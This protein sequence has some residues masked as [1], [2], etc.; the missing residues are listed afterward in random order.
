M[1]KLSTSLI[2]LLLSA[3]IAPASMAGAPPKVDPNAPPPVYWEPEPEAPVKKE[4]KAKGKR[5]KKEKK[6]ATEAA[7]KS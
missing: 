4:R 6:E 1:K 3:S 7:E 2:A 5:E